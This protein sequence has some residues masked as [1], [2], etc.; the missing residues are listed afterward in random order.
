MYSKE[1]TLPRF[2]VI[3]V[4][5]N[6]AELV[7]PT[8]ESVVSQTF[9]QFEYL[10]VD[11]G[12][13]DDTVKVA[14]SIVRPQDRVISEPDK[15][16]YDAMNKGIR[17]ATGDFLLFMNAGDCFASERVLEKV[18]ARLE[19]SDRIVFGRSSTV[20]DLDNP[21]WSASHGRELSLKDFRKGRS[22]SH[23]AEYIHKSL[24][25]SLGEYDLSFPI[26][27]DVEFRARAVGSGIIPR[28]LDIDCAICLGGGVSE[29]DLPR[30]VDERARV[31]WRHFGP[32]PASR[33]CVAKF[34]HRN[35]LVK[36]LLDAL[37]AR[38]ARGD[39]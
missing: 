37:R 26:A 24:F 25:Q 39:Q 4:V 33:Y 18:E 23:Q 14:K 27:A 11:G 1:S 3:T 7:R 8:T 31:L 35:R 34:A 38:R 21:T 15:G 29:S 19:P 13:S 16:I 2:S 5:F 17:A 6:A 30:I 22:Y 9:D 12:S 20:D 36:P 28:F 32:L 10:I